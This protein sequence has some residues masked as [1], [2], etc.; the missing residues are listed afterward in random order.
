MFE[1]LAQ[2]ALLR[3][4][5]DPYIVA[6]IENP[7]SLLDNVSPIWTTTTAP[8]GPAFILVAKFATLIVGDH[9]I[10]GTMLLL[11][12]GLRGR[13]AP[14]RPVWLSD[15]GLFRFWGLVGGGASVAVWLLEYFPNHLGLRL[16][17]NHPLYAAA[18]IGGGEVLRVAAHEGWW[19][20][21]ALRLDGVELPEAAFVH[22]DR[23]L[24]TVEPAQLGASVRGPCV[25][26]VDQGLQE[27]ASADP[28]GFA[29]G[30]DQ[31]LGGDPV[32]G[33]RRLLLAGAGKPLGFKEEVEGY[34]WEPEPDQNLP[35]RFR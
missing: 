35:C 18:W 21:G 24:H 33:H 1:T 31:L 12:L 11:A 4:G 34:V 23:P 19:R 28:V 9:V 29:V 25:Q 16:E 6:P 32:V 20:E 14:V 10:A 26:G 27:L 17:V 5:F 2:G 13:G 15:P 8:Y 7:N 22:T 3:D 30:G